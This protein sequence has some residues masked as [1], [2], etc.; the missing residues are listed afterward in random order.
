MR[1]LFA[2][3]I[4]LSFLL[5]SEDILAMQFLILVYSAALAEFLR[6]HLPHP[7]FFVFA[8]GSMFCKQGIFD[9]QA[10]LC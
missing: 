7:D 8:E 10:G 9:Q 5:L 1:T 2:S 4:F 6:P 3:S